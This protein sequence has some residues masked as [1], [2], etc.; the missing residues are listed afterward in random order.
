MYSF[1][2]PVGLSLT[3]FHV[4]N[5]AIR[6]CMP[7]DGARAY[8]ALDDVVVTPMLSLPYLVEYSVSI[9]PMSP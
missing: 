9:S 8:Y 1:S 5:V 7:L 6:R 2:L 4:T 3:H